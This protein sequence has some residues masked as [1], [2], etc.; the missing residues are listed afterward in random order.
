M[1]P[2]TVNVRDPLRASPVW[3]Y[4][5]GAQRASPPISA[6]RIAHSLRFGY[7]A[8]ADV[9]QRTDVMQ[10]S[11][12]WLMTRPLTTGLTL[13]QVTRPIQIGRP[14]ESVTHVLKVR[15][16]GSAGV[17]ETVHIAPAWQP[18][19]NSGGT[20]A[21]RVGA[22]RDGAGDGDCDDPKGDRCQ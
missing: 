2:D 22:V 21:V 20:R 8:I 5:D 3:H 16:I 1:M 6:C 13:A 19:A 18:M 7:E 15:H 4:A 9:Q 12:D 10:R 14:G 11:I 17:T